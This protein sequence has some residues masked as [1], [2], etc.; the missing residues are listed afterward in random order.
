MP[1]QV[2]ILVD[3]VNN[4]IRLN[5]IEKRVPKRLSHILR[6]TQVPH[7]K[8]PL[9]TIAR[10]DLDFF[11]VEAASGNLNRVYFIEV[12]VIARIVPIAVQ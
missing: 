1:I 5:R 9:E 10:L 6:A 11:A 12:L 8:L 4:H 7:A 2:F 3:N